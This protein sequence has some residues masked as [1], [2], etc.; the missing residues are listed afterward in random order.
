VQSS[1]PANPAKY[2]IECREKGYELGFDYCAF[3]MRLPL[4]FSNPK[5]VMLIN[6]PQAWQQRYAEPNY[7]AVDPAVTSAKSSLKPMVWSDELFASFRPLWRMHA[8]MILMSAG[9]NLH[10]T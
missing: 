6:Y 4:P 8:R 3:G 7:L 1:Y 5:I 10:T 9:P 2:E